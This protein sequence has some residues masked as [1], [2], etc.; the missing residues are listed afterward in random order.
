MFSKSTA[1]LA[2]FAVASR[3]AVAA[4]PPACMLAAIRCA[5]ETDKMRANM[6]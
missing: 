3:V 4:N 1:I 2:L 6:G 5:Q